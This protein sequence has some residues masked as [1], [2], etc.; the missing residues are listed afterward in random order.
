MSLF[1]PTYVHVA[2]ACVR[3]FGTLAAAKLY[4]ERVAAQNGEDSMIYALAAE[5]IGDVITNIAHR[6]AQ[7]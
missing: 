5:S 3:D 6:R 7:A 4:C 2:I 1:K